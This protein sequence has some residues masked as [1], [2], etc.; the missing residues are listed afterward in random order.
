[1]VA[2]GAVH[3]A[4]L[5]RDSRVFTW[6]VGDGGRLGHGDTSDRHK[7]VLVQELHGECVSQVSCAVW[8][9]AAVVVIPPF[10]TGGLLYTWGTGHQGQLGQGTLKTNHTPTPLMDLYEMDV[11]V[12]Y[13]DCGMYHN[14]L[15][16]QD[17]LVFTWGSNKYGCL[18]RPT[19][20]DSS[21]YLQPRFVSLNASPPRTPA[22]RALRRHL[23]R[24]PHQSC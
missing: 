14:A 7:P 6:G 22:L 9:S 20:M 12:T 24:D 18:G 21:E 4:V 17:G 5:L 10:T 3:C 8:H 11:A 23:H 15:I 16:T 1:M 13:V 2:C 19:E